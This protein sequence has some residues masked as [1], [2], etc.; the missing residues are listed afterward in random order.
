MK[1]DILFEQKKVVVTC[2]KSMGDTNEYLKLLKP[3][4]KHKKAIK[5]RQTYVIYG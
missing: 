1:K 3:P 2:E 4:I 5:G